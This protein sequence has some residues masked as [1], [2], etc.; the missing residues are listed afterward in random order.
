MEQLLHFAQL[1]RKQKA[2]NNRVVYILLLYFVE[3]GRKLIF[4]YRELYMDHRIQ[5]RAKKAKK[6]VLQ[7]KPSLGVYCIMLPSNPHNLFDIVSVNELLFSH[8]K[9]YDM[10]IVGLAADKDSAKEL[11]EQIVQTVY[12]DMVY[13]QQKE[14]NLKE[15]FS[16][17]KF[18]S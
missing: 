12:N 16:K 14:F 4:W 3:R 1:C 9:R 17:D 2:E 13:T 5:K 11:L 7:A 10:Y 15:Y 18:V 6:A 8:Y